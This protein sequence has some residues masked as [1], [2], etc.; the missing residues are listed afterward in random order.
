MEKTKIIALTAVIAVLAAIIV[1]GAAYAQTVGKQR[2]TANP[3][4][5]GQV[6]QTSGSAA[7]YGGAYGYPSYSCPGFGGS[8]YGSAQSGYPFQSGLG[9]HGMGMG[10]FHR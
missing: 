7:S 4:V 3:G 2:W 9:M 1:A 6:P 5:Y 10:G 8:A